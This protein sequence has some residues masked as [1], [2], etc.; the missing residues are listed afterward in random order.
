MLVYCK[1]QNRNNFVFI[2]TLFKN[3]CQAG[4]GLQPIS[5]YFGSIEDSEPAETLVR[6]QTDTETSSAQGL[7][8]RQNQSLFNK[9]LMKCLSSI[10]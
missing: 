8:M 1:P 9:N 5:S 7:G 3:T 10:I 6:S 4:S 2:E